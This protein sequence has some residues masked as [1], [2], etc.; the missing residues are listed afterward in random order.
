[1][2][3]VP[4]KKSTGAWRATSSAA[5]TDLMD[6]IVQRLQIETLKAQ[7][8]L[9]QLGC[10]YLAQRCESPMALAQETRE[11]AGL[12]KYASQESGA[13]EFVLKVA[14]GKTKPMWG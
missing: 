7:L 6:A 12:M 14:Q 8:S 9:W 10:A 4:K 5:E 3:P 1:M 11:I 13:L 2:G